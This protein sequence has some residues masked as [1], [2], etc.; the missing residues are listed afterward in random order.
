MT[1]LDRAGIIETGAI[2]LFASLEDD[3]PLTSILPGAFWPGQQH[4]SLPA[5]AV[6]GTTLNLN[7]SA[8][9]YRAVGKGLEWQ[10]LQ[11]QSIR[12]RL[13][14]TFSIL[15]LGLRQEDRATLVLATRAEVTR[16][17][18]ALERD[19]VSIPRRTVSNAAD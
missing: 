7:P 17:L 11:R 2:L 3:R 18:R 6:P 1:D 9:R 10:A 16:N 19:G 5:V 14:R 4:V 12:E 13:E 8:H 15:P